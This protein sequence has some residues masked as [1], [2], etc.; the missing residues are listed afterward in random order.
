MVYAWK[1]AGIAFAAITVSP[2]MQSCCRQERDA[3]QLDRRSLRRMGGAD[4]MKLIS[5]TSI[6]ALAVS[7]VVGLAPAHADFWSDAGAKDRKSVV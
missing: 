5:G 3:R 6:A 1:G 7:M 2:K 4:R